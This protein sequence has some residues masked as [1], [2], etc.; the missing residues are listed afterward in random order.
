LWDAGALEE[1][2]AAVKILQ[3][4]AR[5]DAA[6]S[7]KLEQYFTSGIDNWAVCDAVGMQALQTIVKTH[8]KEIFELAKRH[9]RSANLWDRR[10]SL[11]LVE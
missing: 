8:E 1:K 2:M 10:L 3:K 7:L 4:I 11:V 5:Q 6:K 9:N